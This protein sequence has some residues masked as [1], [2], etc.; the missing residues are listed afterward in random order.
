MVLE[1][2]SNKK[3]TLLIKI[4]ASDLMINGYETDAINAL[5]IKIRIFICQKICTINDR[6]RFSTSLLTM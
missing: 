3:E 6:K 1:E 2:N 4:F 5:K